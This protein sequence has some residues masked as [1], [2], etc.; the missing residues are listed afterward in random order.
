MGI[1]TWF[2]RSPRDSRERR[3]PYIHLYGAAA[4]LIV[5]LGAAAFMIWGLGVGGAGL[6]EFA[7]PILLILSVGAV[8]LV[9]GALIPIYKHA[10][11]TTPT[12][13]LGLPPGSIRALISLFFIVMFVMTTVF[14]QRV[15]GGGTEHLEDLTDAQATAMLGDDRVIGSERIGE[16][17]WTLTV[18]EPAGERT[19]D[20][21][22]RTFVTLSTLITAL[23]AFY[24]GSN[25]VMTAAHASGGRGGTVSITSPDPANPPRLPADGQ[26][27]PGGIHVVATP[28]GA[29]ITGK[30]SSGRLLQDEAT[31]GRFTFIAGPDATA[32]LEFALAGQPGG[33]PARLTL[34]RPEA[35]AGADATT[36][37]GARPA[38]PAAP[39]K[40]G[41]P[42]PG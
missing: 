24:F 2:A 5:L 21:A 10:G 37:A 17:N 39:R 41:A 6:Y 7:L 31:A 23:A 29:R 15:V 36:P 16:N 27:L 14:L 4:I 20:F 3:A 9:L 11:L 34:A 8:V 13:A 38:A 18:R 26:E 33:E 30:T 32:Q 25:S 42:P 35:A 40:R 22:D 12:E 19:A 28:P 1:R